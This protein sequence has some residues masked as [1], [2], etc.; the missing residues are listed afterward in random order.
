[1]VR[2]AKISEAM[3]LGAWRRQAKANLA[4][5]TASFEGKTVLLVGA[6][7]LILSDAARIIADLEVSTL[8]FGVRNTRKGEA[9]A[10]ELRQ[11]HGDRLNIILLEVD[12]LSFGSVQLF[13]AEINNFTRIDA[14]VMG[15]AIMNTE[16]RVTE[17]GWEESECPNVSVV[18]HCSD[19]E[20]KISFAA[21]T[22]LFGAPNHTFA[23]QNPCRRRRT[24]SGV[25]Q[26]KQLSYPSSIANGEAAGE[27][28]RLVHRES[29]PGRDAQVSEGLPIWSFEDHPRML[30]TRALCVSARR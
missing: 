11:K 5:P 23:T 29:Q 14:I 12:L 17:D 27:R 22:P 2:V 3:P 4:P 30:D 24:A 19:E 26:R 10:D 7:G 1:M 16:T 21:R 18:S 9:L 25:E 8:I 20:T 6:T 13:A 15:S 28:R